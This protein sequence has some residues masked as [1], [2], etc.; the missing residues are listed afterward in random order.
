MLEKL[1]EM[2]KAKDS[3]V[4]KAMPVMIAH[5]KLDGTIVHRNDPQNGDL[6]FLSSMNFKNIYDILP[7]DTAKLMREKVQDIAKS[8]KVGAVEYNLPVDGRIVNLEARVLVFGE[9]DVLAII[10]DNSHRKAA[11]TA[12]IQSKLEA[13]ASSRTKSEFIANM[14]HELRT[15][16]NSIIGFSDVINSESHGP[17]NEPQKK[18]ISNVIRNGKHLSSIIND[19][20]SVSNIESGKVEFHADEFFA[21]DLI[22][23]VEAMMAPIALEKGID[24]ICNIDIEMPAIKAD[25]IKFKQIVYNLVNNAIKFSDKG[26]TVAIEGNVSGGF[27]HI[28]VKDRGI[29]ISPECQ[30]KLFNPFYQVDASVSRKYGGVGLGLPL[31][32]N[33]TE[34]HGGYVHVESKEGEG[35]TFTVS[36]PLEREFDASQSNEQN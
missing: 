16:L 10:M 15:P 36:L 6:F 23:E 17:L 22:N 1:E 9:D 18:Y 8:N 7:D 34:M 14:S 21:S 30:D 29:G 12:L 2:H 19:I 5:M 3:A 20:L 13:E 26:G 4:M 35:S 33:F 25:M 32:K 31:V 11:E 28:S 27:M 24:V